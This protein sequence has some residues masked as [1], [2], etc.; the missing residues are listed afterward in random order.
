MDSQNQDD[1]EFEP[2]TG[3]D[4]SSADTEGD[5]ATSHMTMLSEDYS[6]ESERITSSSDLEVGSSIVESYILPSMSCFP[7]RLFFSA[8]ILLAVWISK[9]CE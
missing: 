7:W 5:R 9:A 3:S 8:I 1:R 6:S 4:I 2:I